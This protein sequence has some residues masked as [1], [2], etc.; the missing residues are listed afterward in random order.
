MTEIIALLNHYS[1]QWADA[2]LRA[3]WQ[4]TLLIAAIWLVCRALPNL[5]VTVRYWLWWLACFKLL[6]GLLW[7]TPITLPWLPSVDTMANFAGALGVPGFAAQPDLSAPLAAV[8][9]AT[10]PESVPQSLTTASYVMLIWSA[11]MMG[12][13]C[14][15]GRQYLSLRI[16][17]RGAGPLAAKGV[18]ERLATLTQHLRLRRNVPVL[19][20]PD[21][22]S[23]VVIGPARPVVLLPTGISQQLSPAEID[24]AVAH[25]LT[26]VKKGDLWLAQIPALVQMLFFFHPLAWLAQREWAINC[27]AACDEATVRLVEA[28][29]NEY[30]Q[31]LLKLVTAGRTPRS[32]AVLSASRDY[33]MIRRR[34]TDLQGRAA[35]SRRAVVGSL[36]LLVVV[37]CVTVVPCQVTARPSHLL[38]DG[39]IYC[40]PGEQPTKSTV[41]K[42][43]AAKVTAAAA[44]RKTVS[45]PLAAA[46]ALE[47]TTVTKPNGVTPGRRTRAP[48]TPAAPILVASSPRM[49]PAKRA[50]DV[51]VSPAPAKTTTVYGPVPVPAPAV[52]MR[53]IQ[54]RQATPRILTSRPSA[55]I[56]VEPPATGRAYATD[57]YTQPTYTVG[58]KAPS[59]D[60]PVTEPARETYSY[61]A[62]PP[63]PATTYGRPAAPRAYGVKPTT[64]YSYGRPKPIDKPT[65][66]TETSYYGY[67][68]E[69]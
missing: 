47:V 10:I 46:K 27:E 62:E 15:I 54:P 20:S 16:L 1:T 18:G 55:T 35:R 61:I 6:V 17:V 59:V 65:P 53:T 60:K 32:S 28:S 40:P 43:V 44:T 56:S 7:A 67:E 51:A 52:S 64:S 34:L 29:P 30:G 11:C 39:E 68:A 69:G 4:G 3:C 42:S 22:S 66:A 48:I 50:V 31:V 5:P 57:S 12:W 13:A 23:P 41:A 14:I 8:A 63:V 45:I 26:H 58:L 38:A 25:E 19:L 36:V 2:M 49:P 21:V 9:Y 37:T 24:M 33:R